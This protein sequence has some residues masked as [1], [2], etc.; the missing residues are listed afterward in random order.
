MPR[1]QHFFDEGEIA[2][3]RNAVAAAV[4]SLTCALSLLYAQDGAGVHWPSF[5]GPHASGVAEGYKT[6][7]EWDL[8]SG[9]NIAW[10]TEIPGLGHS[11][12]I[13]WGSRIFVTSA[14]SGKADPE[15]KVGLY[16]NI[17]PVEDDSVHRWMLYCIDK[18]TGK[19][20]WQRI[21]HEGVPK[22]KRHTKSTHANST[23]V[24]DGRH[25]VA[26]FGSEGLYCYDLDG[27]LLW[28]KDLGVL[29]AGY[30]RVPAA[31][32]GTGSSP[33]IF[34]GMVIVQCDVQSG[35]F[36]AAFRLE[37]GSEAWR[38]NRKDVP[39]WSTPTVQDVAGQS[40]LLVN[41]YNHIGGYDAHTGDEVWRMR[42]GGDIP[43]PTPIVAKG[44][45]FFTNAHGGPSPI[46]AVH[47][48]ARGEIA[49]KEGETANDQVAW[50]IPRGG[51]YM[52]TPII[53]RD[54]LYV[55]RDNGV[56]RVFDAATGNQAIDNVRLPGA[57]YTSS[58]VAADGK[59]YFTS[60][61]GE[62]SVV[63]AG[64]AFQ[65]LALNSLDEIHMSSPAISEG[66]LYFRT[67]GHLTA[68]SD[69]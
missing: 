17:Q 24:S 41:G 37:D 3:T 45:A 61:E 43:V 35:S 34:D 16:G 11:S 49:L 65:Q 26:F 55:C 6:P 2:L 27:N 64:D 21:A 47:L 62:V 44:L 36:L 29:D 60:E 59:V 48:Q 66:A 58:P 4:S 1:P 63:A 30:Y 14:I 18:A 5:R 50:S 28:K 54:R 67:K 46:Y 8:A 19:I 42:G 31:Q 13:V 40:L 25:V 53:Y 9:K 52:P 20:L 69:R 7:T 51:A 39:T 38:S 32:W 23:P 33:I 68:V 15:L 10:R 12:P 56:L 22:I 57:A